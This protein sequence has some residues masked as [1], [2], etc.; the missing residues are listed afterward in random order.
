[1]DPRLNLA[2]LQQILVPIESI[3][4]SIQ[5]AAYDFLK[6]YRVMTKDAQR[7][8]CIPVCKVSHRVKLYQKPSVCQGR[9]PVFLCWGFLQKQYKFYESLLTI[10]LS[11]SHQGESLNDVELQRCKG[12][13]LQRCSYMTSK[14]NYIRFLTD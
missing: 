6:N 1:M 13:L 2:A 4:H 10:G 9:R 14:I 3:C 7:F 11:L 5:V 8:R 12:A